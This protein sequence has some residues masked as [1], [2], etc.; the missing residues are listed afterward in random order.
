MPAI[1]N[2]GAFCSAAD[3]A[4]NLTGTTGTHF[5]EQPVA[6]HGVLIVVIDPAAVPAR[7]K[8]DI[9][10]KDIGTGHGVIEDEIVKDGAPLSCHPIDSLQ[11]HAPAG[12]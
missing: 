3:Q 6:R 1:V 4:D 2:F 11:V 10:V 7:A 8:V 5:I 12:S 9:G